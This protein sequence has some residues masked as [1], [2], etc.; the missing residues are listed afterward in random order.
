MYTFHLISMTRRTLQNRSPYFQS[1][2][3]SLD[4]HEAVP[5]TSTT[6][7]RL[8]TFFIATLLA[9]QTQNPYNTPEAIEQGRALF[10]TH[11]A[12]CHGARGE[13]GRGA[14][15]TTGQYRQGGSDSNLYNTINDGVPGTD[16]PA[17]RVTVEE[18]WKL[19]AFVKKIGSAG[20][21]EKSSGDPASGKAIYQ[22]KGGCTS[23]HAIGPNGGSLGPPL[24]DVGR[25]RGLKHL[26]QSLLTPEA[27]VAIRYR[28][29]QVVLNSGQTISGTR[30]NEDDISV[31]LRDQRDN[32]RSF[33][34][35]NIKEIRRDKPS[36]MPAYGS[37]LS[38]KEMEDL[39]AYLSSLRGAE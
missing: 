37:I 13:G 33:L 5:C 14:D 26:E 39:V 19:V 28:A 36:L 8:A 11:C 32:A 12:Y 3:L 27:D 22:G 38:K 20:L 30:L 18:A 9:A 4:S 7:L 24:D 10:Q 31:Q 17:V 6:L 29:I 15:L 2:D 25:R 1:R 16:M 23:C 35:S 21:A 34:K